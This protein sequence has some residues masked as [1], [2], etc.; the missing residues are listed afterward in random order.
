[1]STQVTVTP[2]FTNPGPDVDVTAQIFNAVNQQRQ[3]QVSY[4][5]TD[6]NGQAVFTSNPVPVTL[7]VNFYVQLSING[8]VVQTYLVP[9]V[10]F[11]RNY[12]V[13]E[14]QSLLTQ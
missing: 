5:V 4:T 3:A 11:H 12:D 10:P 14:I 8:H 6:G 13:R 2:P 9:A 1:M 7:S